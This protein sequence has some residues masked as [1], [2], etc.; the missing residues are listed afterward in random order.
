M[1]ALSFSDT[2]KKQSRMFPKERQQPGAGYAQPGNRTSREMEVRKQTP[3]DREEK[4]P[5]RKQNGSRMC[6]WSPGIS[7]L[8]LRGCSPVTS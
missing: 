2:H 5:G 4:G 3:A 8:I 7:V 6:V 1:A